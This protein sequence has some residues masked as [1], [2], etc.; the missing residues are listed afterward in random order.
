MIPIEVAA[1]CLDPE[2]RHALWHE[3]RAATLIEILEGP[4]AR[5]A[6]LPILFLSDDARQAAPW[7]WGAL[8]EASL[9]QAAALAACGLARG[10]PVVLAIPTSGLFFPVFFGILAAGGVPVPVAPPPSQRVE[11]LHWYRELL[12]TIVSDSGARI[13]MSNTGHRQTLAMVAP[14]GVRVLAADALSAAAPVRPHTLDADELALLQYT[15]GS[16]SSPKGVALTHANIIANMHAIGTEIV[17]EHS[18]GVSW[19]PLFHDMGLIGAALGALYTRTPILLLPT[20]RFGK[21]PAAW[22]RAIGAFGATITQAPNFAFAHAV[23]YAAVEDLAGVSLASLRTALNGAEPIDLA[24]VEAFERTF[25]PLGLRRGIVR[26]VY[27]L[28]ESSLAVTFADAGQRVVDEIDADALESR[29]VAAPASDAQR[30]RTIVSVGRP[31]ATQEIRIAGESGIPRG[32]REIGEVLVRGPSVMRGYYRRPEETAATLAGGWLHTGDLGYLSDGRLYLTGRLKD[33]IIRHG[34]NYSP[35]DLEHVISGVEGV[36][37]GGSV[38]FGIDR[39]DG[40]QVVIVVETRLRR[41]GDHEALRRRIREAC[42]AAFLF[43][44]DDVRLVPAGGIPRTTSGK[45]RRSECRSLYLDAALPA[46]TRSD[47]DQSA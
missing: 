1:K 35:S 24:T 19:L 9:A 28:A 23:R 34:R 38:A 25:A 21:E 44:P 37:R 31:L 5:Y 6:S 18:S 40:P 42:Q 22:L 26:P 15:S 30:R 29:G 46:F 27:G 3:P 33:L 20:T 13:L 47:A 41:P 12:S 32:E 7:S 10:E 2:R 16:T 8:W 4:A 17:D 43:G 14:E 11:R 39:E 45:V 36:L